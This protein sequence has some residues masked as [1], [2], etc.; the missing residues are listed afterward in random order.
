[1]E[2]Q[3]SSVLQWAKVGPLT[4]LV[5]SLVPGLIIKTDKLSSQQNSPH[6]SLTLK[7]RS[8]SPYIPI[9]LTYLTCTEMDA[10]W[11]RTVYCHKLYEVETPITVALPDEV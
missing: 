2:F 3:L 6:G 7:C 8:D 11:N 9:Q 10:S 4:P 1:M 5:I